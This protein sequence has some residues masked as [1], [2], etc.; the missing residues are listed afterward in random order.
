MHS[1]LSLKRKLAVVTLLVLI[2]TVALILRFNINRPPHPSQPIPPA[3]VVSIPPKEQAKSWLPVR[4][5]IPTLKIDSAIEYLGVTPGGEMDTPKDPNKVAW[6]KP[7]KRPGENG[8]AVITGHSGWK[9]KKPAVF[10]H[11]SKVQIGEKIYVEDET[12]ATITFVVREL[13]D[14]HP[15]YDAKSIFTSN[16]GKSHLN[17]ITCEGTWNEATKSYSKR[18]VAFADKQ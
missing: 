8:S 6:Y 18:L 11:L 2:P 9:N 16:D 3:T 7:G 4:L 15:S 13:K 10:D 12:G 5:K 1:K 14:Y 17:L